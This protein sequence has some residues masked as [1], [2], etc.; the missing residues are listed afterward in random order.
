[1]TMDRY[2]SSTVWFE[3][4]YPRNY[5]DNIEVVRIDTQEGSSVVIYNC[6]LSCKSLQSSDRVGDKGAQSPS[7]FEG[8]HLNLL[9][10]WSVDATWRDI[11]SQLR[12]LRK[13]V[14]P[15]SCAWGLPSDLGVIEILKWGSWELSH[16]PATGYV[17]WSWQGSN[18]DHYKYKHI[19]ML[20][21]QLKRFVSSNHCGVQLYGCLFNFPKT[22]LSWHF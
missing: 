21:C 15:R 12:C 1:M 16:V 13:A 3:S 18:F 6:L 10:R 2:I 11:G 4:A 14:W 22:R 9:L 5:K 19:M 17:P 7:R 8:I 20:M